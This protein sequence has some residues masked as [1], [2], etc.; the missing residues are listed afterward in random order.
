MN[1]ERTTQQADVQTTPDVIAQ[2]PCGQA[3]GGVLC[4]SVVYGKP[5]RAHSVCGEHQCLS[6]GH[7]SKRPDLSGIQGSRCTSGKRM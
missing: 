3:L 5:F 6:T 4:S 2:R 1:E 7:H